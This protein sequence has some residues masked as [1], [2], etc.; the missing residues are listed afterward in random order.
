[1]I[2]PY[3]AN[4]RRMEFSERT[5]PSMRVRVLSQSKHTASN[6]GGCSITSELHDLPEG[7]QRANLC[8]CCLRQGC[9]NANQCDPFRLPIGIPDL[10]PRNVDILPA[11]N[12]RECADDSR[13]VGV[14]SEEHV[15]LRHR[16]DIVFIDADETRQAFP[17]QRSRRACDPGGGCHAH[18]DKGEVI[19][20]RIGPD[21]AH[22]NSLPLR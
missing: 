2:L 10:H 11:K 3:D 21:L 16:F 8:D 20:S 9:G 17:E 14:A 12:A 4:Q 6:L 15:S 18:F 19:M 1:M 5:M 7:W 22:G 13:L